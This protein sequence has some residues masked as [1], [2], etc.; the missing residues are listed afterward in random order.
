M[1]K[2]KKNRWPGRENCLPRDI[3]THLPQGQPSMTPKDSVPTFTLPTTFHWHLGPER[4]SQKNE[5]GMYRRSCLTEILEDHRILCRRNH[6]SWMSVKAWKCNEG[7]CVGTTCSS[8]WQLGRWM[9]VSKRVGTE[10]W[11]G[12]FMKCFFWS[13]SPSKA[14]SPS[15][16]G[17]FRSF[18]PSDGV[19]INAYSTMFFSLWERLVWEDNETLGFTGCKSFFGP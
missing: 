8:A 2:N 3:S 19:V 14:H 13:V 5:W 6:F 11:S 15:V 10:D 4:K 17:F 16:P 1:I 7:R 12:N 18:R 9:G